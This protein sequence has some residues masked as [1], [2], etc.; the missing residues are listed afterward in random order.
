MKIRGT[1]VKFAGLAALA[2][3]SCTG[4]LVARY[5]GGRRP[6]QS[7][8]TTKSF[9]S[10]SSSQTG[11]AEISKWNKAYGSLALSFIE[12]QGQT[13]QEVRYVSHGSRY[14]LFLTPQ[15]AV[16]TLRQT[17][18]Y[19]M[20][21]RHRAQTLKQMRADRRAAPGTTTALRMQFEGANSAP[22]VAGAEKLPGIVNYYIGNDPKKWHR[23]VPTFAEVK[24]A[25][26]YPGVDL[27]FYGNQGKLEYDFVVAP[28]ADPNAIRLHLVGARSLRRDA[29]GN[30]VVSLKGGEVQLQKPVIYQQV[31]GRRQ[32][33]A[34]HYTVAGD[35]VSFALANYDRSA[36]LII[37]PVLNYSTYLGGTADDGGNAIVIDASGDAYV[38]GF[39]SSTDF[40][41]AGV[42]AS[43]TNTSPG[44]TGFISELNPTGTAL[45]QSAYLG[46]SSGVDEITALAID[47][48]D[49]VYAT[50]FTGSTDFPTMTATALKPTLSSNANGTSFIVESNSSGSLFY[51]SYLG[52]TNG[53]FGQGIAADANGNAYVTGVTYSTPGTADVDFPIMNAIQTT[54][55]DSAGSAFLTKINTKSS[56]IDSLLYSTYLGGDGAN[57]VTAD[58]GFGDEGY[59]VAAD[60]TGKAYISGTT[61]SS[62]FPV[63][64]VTYQAAP[65]GTNPSSVFLSEI[66]TTITTGAAS[67]VYSTYIGGSGDSPLGDFGTGI[68]LKSGTTVA[69]IT[70]TTDSA[71]FPTTTGAYQTTCD[72]ANGSAF[73][74]LL[75]TS[76]GTSLKY[77]TCLG[78]GSST[79]YSVQADSTTG[80][81]V[82]GG[83]TISPSF[84]VTS[85]AFQTAL[86]IGNTQ[87]NGF[88]SQISPA[89]NGSADLIYSTYFGGVATN[90]NADQIFGL[91]LST[92][93]TVY[94]T[95]QTFSSSATFPV[96]SGAFQ[97]SLSGPS[98][99]FVSELTLEPT[100]VVS[101]TS[102]TFTAT[103]IGTITAG[104]SVTL[105]NNTAAAIIF[106]SATITNPSPAAAATDFAISADTCGASIAAGGSC[107]VTVTF[108]PTTT[109]ESATLTL[110]D[111]DSSS[112]QSVALSG[113]APPLFVVSPT[114]LTFSSPAVGTAT[115]AQTVTLTNNGTSA[116]AF[117]SATVALTSA[118]GA[119][120]DFALLPATTCGA[121][122]AAGG[123]TCTVSVTYTPSV[124]T[125]ETATLTL[126]DGAPS[127]PQVIMLT[128]N[129]TA[130]SGFT[131]TAQNT[132]LMVTQGQ[133]ASETITV[134]SV[135]TFAGT[136]D[137]ACTGQPKNSKCMLSSKSVTLT[138]GSSVPIT[139]DFEAQSR[140]APP[141]ASPRVPQ[142][143]FRIVAPVALV[144]MVLLLFASQQRLRTRF[145]LAGA[146]LVFVALAGC[147]RTSTTVGSYPVTITGTSSGATM[148]TVTVTVVVAK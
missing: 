71:D 138:A 69:Y 101:P 132:M 78:G 130:A 22:Q 82:V 75:D 73:V 114:T 40:P 131:L 46:G 17:K 49:N 119:T 103:A 137:L 59:D 93:P 37:D 14:D 122:I 31:A 133:S 9:F 24:Y 66:D 74:T 5:H 139:L 87:G 146:L 88:I 108:D 94:A 86:P 64:T 120:A 106:T 110:T 58:L 13:A 25:Q 141:P 116:V 145:A 76:V 47:S 104:Q 107:T 134:T 70:G 113:T 38:G 84:P 12:N 6:S 98:D 105:T 89:G 34:G 54:L 72:A 61:T 21:P 32:E 143:P 16:V 20:S 121:S 147:S 148:Q 118:A 96:T 4:L 51:S 129:V 142:G 124:A 83:S 35:R 100:L 11:A 91:A 36:P 123:G 42:G 39:T 53:D 85:G 55:T 29:Q 8:R 50:G 127:S 1:A 97:T 56:G 90:T 15:E 19:D 52:G 115:A 43:T 95:G 28:G 68:A 33:V 99:A 80:D 117:T 102:L 81:A 3:L 144:L 41:V 77:S 126:V 111:G 112:P 65:K 63:S 125:A 10:A 79:G 57:N 26:V 23:N 44:M 60:S 109:T 140:L 136:V 18:H 45:V 67:L 128:G 30:V 7:S 2:L 135:G 92:L 62:N 27:V 48:S